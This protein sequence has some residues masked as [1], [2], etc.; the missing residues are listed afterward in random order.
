MK[1]KIIAGIMGAAAAAL[2]VYSY[3][4]LPETVAVQIGVDGQVSNTMPKMFAV[5]LP[6]VITLGGCGVMV[7]GKRE[8]T[9]KGIVLSVAGIG[10]MIVTV[11]FNR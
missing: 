10:I 6:L 1:T 9:V 4:I 7:F 3:M 5:V 8:S 2:A 11:L